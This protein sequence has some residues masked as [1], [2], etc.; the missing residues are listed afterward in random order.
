MNS[1][2][3]QILQKQNLELEKKNK[4]LDEY[5]FINSHQ[6]RAPV[7][8]ILGLVEL[9]SHMELP[10]EAQEIIARMKSESENLDA[11]VRNISR[12]IQ[13]AESSQPASCAE[14]NGNS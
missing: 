7:A 8:R 12:V 4:A 9:C 13:E 3:E 11:V 6:L 5:A 1:S 10:P 2:I 14:R